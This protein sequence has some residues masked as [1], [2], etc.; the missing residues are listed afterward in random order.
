MLVPPVVSCV[1]TQL[2][3]ELPRD[4]STALHA[5]H[6]SYSSLNALIIMGWEFISASMSVQSAASWFWV[7]KTFP[8]KL[9]TSY[10][11]FRQS[12]QNTGSNLPRRLWPVSVPVV[13][14]VVLILR[15]KKKKRVVNLVSTRAFYWKNQM[16][17][18]DPSA[19]VCGMASGSTKPYKLPAHPA[20]PAPIEINIK[21][22]SFFRRNT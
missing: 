7:S 14:Q 17:L 4:L 13:F 18:S 16:I 3:Q 9:N 15:K 6:A 20:P 5:A 2:K 8:N 11:H 10:M 21:S 12:G 19:K 1:I 22:M